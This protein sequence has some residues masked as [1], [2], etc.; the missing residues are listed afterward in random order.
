MKLNS[1]ELDMIW[2]LIIEVTE[3]LK[4]VMR[5][6]NFHIAVCN[7]SQNMSVDN[8][9]FYLK[10]SISCECEVRF[11]SGVEMQVFHYVN[12]RTNH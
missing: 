7:S 9:I 4:S 2:I 10:N 6:L 12:Q 1:L 11:K 3:T 5:K 8:L